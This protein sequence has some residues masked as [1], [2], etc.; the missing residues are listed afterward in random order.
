MTV[1]GE[2]YVLIRPDSKGFAGQAEREVE[3]GLGGAVKKAAL[4]VG[5][6]MA[7]GGA[8]EFIGSI[9]DAARES[10]RMGKQ[11]EAVLKSTGGAAGISAAQVDKLATSLSNLTGID[12][13]AIQNNENLLLTFTNIKNRVGEGNDVFNRATALT[14]DM[15]K[16]LGEDGASASIQLGKALN[17]PIKGITALTRV[18]VSFTA[19]QKDQIKSLVASGNTL[20]AQKIILG[21]LTREFGGSAAAQATAAD[22]LAVTW[23]NLKETLGKKLLPVIDT[24]AA[25]LA[26][27]LPGALDATFA[28]FGRFGSGISTV[29]EA[30]QMLSGDDG[31][32]GFAEIMDNL[33]GNTGKYVSIFR[34][35]G[36]SIVEV[37]KWIND[38]LIPA[39]K[40]IV[41]WLEDHWVPVLIGATVALGLLTAPVTTVVAGFALL[42]ARSE[43]F[44]NGIQRVIDILRTFGQFVQRD[45]VPPITKAFAYIA[46][47][48]TDLV[49]FFS[50]RFDKIRAA[51]SNVL[52]ALKV[53]FA[54]AFAPIIFLVSQFGDELL[55][56][57]SS[58]FDQLKLVVDT[59]LRVVGDL[60]DF[61]IA[62]LTGQWGD[63]WAAIADIPAAFLDFITGSISNA[64]SIIEQLFSIV[65]GSIADAWNAAWSAI[66][67]AAAAALGAVVTSVSDSIG[68]IVGFVTGLPGTLA[69]AA[70]GLWDWFPEGLKAAIDTVIDLFNKGID[71]LNSFQIH[72]HKTMPSIIP[73]IDIDWDGLHIPHLPMLA[74]GAFVKARPGGMLANI[75]EGIHDEVVMPLPPGLMDSLKKLAAGKIG[76][77][78]G[79]NVHGPLVGQLV[80]PAVEQ[81]PTMIAQQMRA[82]AQRYGR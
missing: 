61:I 8:K 10:E 57:L 15:S 21:E 69:S 33:L 55:S 77:D 27:E 78:G 50:E 81:T 80:S 52:V 38:P 17:D 43:T 12:D 73:N 64:F 60:F 72:V 54:I 29:V 45:V 34:T 6:A 76:G 70:A 16:A 24:V 40:D 49:R 4:L 63:A 3:S 31:P 39:V 74:E 1:I 9:V 18:G 36:E 68:S 62:L 19:Q 46:Q 2:A 25:F 66:W 82:V 13:E 11:T 5:G 26:D 51:V 59:A 41:S 75:G 37:G 56:I 48:V 20:D 23:D 30:F 79:V 65:G 53:V 22:R 47:E 28:A 58:A 42:Y 44:R 35:I 14:L 32:Q 67:S 7:L 71:F